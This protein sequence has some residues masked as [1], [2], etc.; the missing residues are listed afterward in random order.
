MRRKKKARAKKRKERKDVLAAPASI[1][2]FLEK[3]EKTCKRATV[4][5]TSLRP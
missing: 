3:I 2:V 5:K 4:G 1:T